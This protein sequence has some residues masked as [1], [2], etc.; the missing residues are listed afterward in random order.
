MTGQQDAKLSFALTDFG[1]TPKNFDRVAASV[2]AISE[3]TRAG[4]NGAT[5]SVELNF[6]RL[7]GERRKSAVEKVEERILGIIQHRAEHPEQYV[8][9][10]T[11][12]QIQDA[13]AV[14][15]TD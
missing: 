13:M 6:G 9:K 2:G 1:V 10:V 4:V 11:P 14:Y 5:L 12:E 7:T 8:P 15:A 3:V